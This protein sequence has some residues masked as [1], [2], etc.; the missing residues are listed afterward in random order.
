MK[1]RCYT[2]STFTFI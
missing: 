2:T 1:N